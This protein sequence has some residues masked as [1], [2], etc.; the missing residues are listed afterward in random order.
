MGGVAL[1]NLVLGP[2]FYTRELKE[3]DLTEVVGCHQYILPSFG[4]IYAVHI[5]TV[6]SGWPDA[7]RRS[8]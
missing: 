7:L 5:C 6:R 4:T 1:I 8:E 2:L 3:L